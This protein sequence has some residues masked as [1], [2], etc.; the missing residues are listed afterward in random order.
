[1]FQTPNEQQSSTRR[2]SPTGVPTGPTPGRPAQEA[3]PVQAPMAREGHGPRP[4]R[5]PGPVPTALRPQDAA[6]NN[7]VGKIRGKPDKITLFSQM[8][9]SALLTKYQESY[10]IYVWNI[11]EKEEIEQT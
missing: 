5:C 9:T 1:M 4:Q 6:L 2:G 7:R 8:T 10:F 11:K 3:W